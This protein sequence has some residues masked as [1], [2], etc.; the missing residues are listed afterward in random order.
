VKLEKSNEEY[1]RLN[2]QFERQIG[3]LTEQNEVFAENNAVLQDEVNKLE[4][5]ATYL[6]CFLWPASS[7]VCCRHTCKLFL[8]VFTRSSV[9]T[10]CSPLLQFQF[11]ANTETKNC[12]TMSCLSCLQNETAI[13]NNAKFSDLLDELSS[14]INSSRSAH[15]SLLASAYTDIVKR[16]DCVT[17]SIFAP[18][19]FWQQGTR[20]GASYPDV[21]KQTNKVLGDICHDPTDLQNY[22]ETESK[23]RW[24]GVKTPADLKIDQYLSE[25][26][27]YGTA[28]VSYYFDKARSGIEWYQYD[29]ACDNLPAGKNFAW[30]LHK[31]KA[32]EYI[33]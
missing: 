8:L 27:R 18:Y 30:E 9:L 12:L 24:A 5:V 17:E 6:V 2:K 15:D 32:L 21:L 23:S 13:E 10:K 7:L 25:I 33:D 1:A 22:L 29:H 14:S 19:D 26:Q 4:T 31:L 16:V 20:M 3:N 11:T 28:M